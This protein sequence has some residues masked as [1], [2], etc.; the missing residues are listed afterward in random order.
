MVADQVCKALEKLHDNL[1]MSQDCSFKFLGE[2]IG[3][4][5]MAGQA[6]NTFAVVLPALEK[7]LTTSPLWNRICARL[8]TG[9]PDGTMEH[10]AEGLLKVANNPTLIAKLFVD[11][12]LVN[13]KLKYLL[14]TKFLLMR[15]Y[16]NMN[17]LYN[18]IG[19]FIWMQAQAFVSGNCA[20]TLRQLG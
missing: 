12:I 19:Y 10:V 14:T 2:L 6:E 1:T 11:S 9:V 5:C 7:W 3:R 13:T 8:I 15:S 17:V 16:S 20:Y 4:I 18:I